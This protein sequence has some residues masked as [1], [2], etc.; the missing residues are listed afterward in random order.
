MTSSVRQLEGDAA[1]FAQRQD[2]VMVGAFLLSPPP[3][4]GPK[5]TSGFFI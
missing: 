2:I 4:G 1:Q 5:T 3:F